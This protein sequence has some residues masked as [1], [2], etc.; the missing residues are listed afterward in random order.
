MSGQLTTLFSSAMFMPHG[1]CY[2]WQPALVWLQVLSNG[3]IAL[4]YISIFATLVYLVRR[5]QDIPFQWMYVAFATFIVACGVTHIFDVYV[6]WHPEY[7]IDGVVRAVTAVASIGTALMLPP[8]VPKAVAL[9][10]AAGVAHERGLRLEDANKELASLLDKTKE[11]EQLKTQFFANV[12]HELRTPLALILGPTQ[13][14]LTADNLSDSQ[15]RDLEVVLRNARSLLSQ[16]NDLLDVA[17]L[18]AGKVEPDYVDIDV[19][20]LVRLTASNF[21]SLAVERGISYD[22]RAPGEVRGEVDAEKLQRVVLNLLSNAFKFTPQGGSVHCE[23]RVH[24][25]SEAAL[26][27]VSDSGPGIRPEHREA[28][29]DRFRQLEGGTTRRFG[30][31][32]L[33]L[34]IAKDFV[35]LHGGHITLA[36]AELGGALFRVELPLHA[37]PGVAVHKMAAADIENL[38][39][40]SE[41]PAISTFPPLREPKVA[42]GPH[43]APVPETGRGQQALVLVV[44]DNN[45]LNRFI[46]A[47]LAT[48]QRVATAMNGME[49][50]RLARELLPELVVTDLMMPE[51]GG[52]ELLRGLR[53]EPSLQDVPV[54]VLTAKADDDL[55]LELLRSGAQDYILKPFSAEELR[56]RVQNL[57]AMKRARDLL[58]ADLQSTTDS[59][60]ELAREVAARQQAL[61]TAMES[62]RVARDQ[63][64]HA[65]EVKTNFLS[66][67]SH[68]LRTPL[69]VMR[70]QI[71]RASRELQG[72]KS[73]KRQRIFARLDHASTRLEQLVESLLDYARI[74]SGRLDLQIEPTQLEALAR[75]AIEELRPQAEEKKLSIE[76]TPPEQL[77]TADTDPRLVHLIVV[78]LLANAIKFT[79][80]GQ[81]TV[82]LRADGERRH[83]AVTD[84]GPG[85]PQHE[86]SRIFEPFEQLEPVR[87]KHIPGVGLGLALVRE[88]AHALGGEVL[89]QSEVGRGSTFV[90]SIPRALRAPSS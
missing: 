6:I 39:Q 19:A 36:D 35:E 28:V 49:G 59:L 70:L 9:A 38:A 7:W 24:Q 74:Q 16:V 78:N 73:D 83:I 79:E 2:L 77:L 1:H 60:E 61:T 51:M 10:E 11:L 66:M 62:L 12:S 50:L 52:D 71:D 63:A 32:G 5:I 3:G 68:E 22:V 46:A 23:L 34:A 4:A 8:L 43:A 86:Q 76:F 48:E 57:V 87:R 88:M 37:A 84:T 55:R 69:T 85:I 40:L 29:F 65:S 58:R 20:S 17:K 42:L 26:I 82:R 75:A 45:E 56:V 21:E 89:L 13:A 72:E 64:L 15:R 80:R 90:L 54:I 41:H 53:A 27:E 44:E 31:T 33:G 47:T 67:V 14:L 30:G 25:A 18:E 81:I